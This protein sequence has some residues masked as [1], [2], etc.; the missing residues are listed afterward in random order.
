MSRLRS[1]ILRAALLATVC[2]GS[3]V[4]GFI[5]QDPDEPPP[6]TEPGPAPASP[7]DSG[8]L[9]LA[10]NRS[11]QVNPDGTFLVNNVPSTLGLVRVRFVCARASGI[12]GGQTGFLMP[13]AGDK[14][15][16]TRDS[17]ESNCPQT[18]ITTGP[19]VTVGA[20]NVLNTK[21]RYVI[22]V[23]YPLGS[24]PDFFIDC[25]DK[26]IQQL[27]VNGHLVQRARIDHHFT[28]GTSSCHDD[29]DRT[30]LPIP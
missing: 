4:H 8:C 11:A 21:D 5:E 9:A 13:A 19:P 10:M 24:P 2:S 3:L 12:L 30:L 25:R 27:F 28:M 20:N 18:E 6:M 16:V 17:A 23:P 15:T 14:E 26:W 22:Q 1:P 7:L 29:V